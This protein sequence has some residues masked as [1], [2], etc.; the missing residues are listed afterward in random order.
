M[1][2]SKRHGDDALSRTPED[3]VLSVLVHL[4][5]RHRKPPAQRRLPDQPKAN[6]RFVAAHEIQRMLAT[7]DDLPALLFRSDAP[8]AL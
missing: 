1:F 5:A 7:S 3:Y 4:K 2:E 6:L 8:G